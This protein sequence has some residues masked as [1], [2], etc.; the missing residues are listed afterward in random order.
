MFGHQYGTNSNY[1]LIRN[2]TTMLSIQTAAPTFALPDQTGTVRTLSEFAGSWL[3]IYFYPKDDTPGCTT[4]ACTIAAV[5]DDFKALGITVVG[6]SK[7]TPQSHAVFAAKYHLPFVLLSDV[8]TK[9]I[10]AYGAWGEK[11]M[12]GKKYL[13]INRVSYLIDSTGVIVE[14]FPKV[15]PANHALQILTAVRS[16]STSGLRTAKAL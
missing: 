12:F 5:Y 4:E 8:T 10:Q 15:D 11:S 14:V 2:L 3:L 1:V 6:V 9:M 16:Q 13:G 7:D